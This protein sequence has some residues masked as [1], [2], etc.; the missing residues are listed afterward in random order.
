MTAFPVLLKSSL[1][2]YYRNRSAM[3][4]SLL[5]PLM[6][7]VIFGLLNLGANNISETVGVVD[8][9]HNDSSKQV[10]ESLQRV[11]L[12]KLRMG[13]EEPERAALQ[14]GERALVLVLPKAMG[15][16]PKTEQGAPAPVEITIYTNKAKPQD[17][18]IAQAI[19]IQ[20]LDQASFGALGAP[21]GVYHPK[22][23]DLPGQN[24][25]Y[26]DFLVPGIIALSIMQ[27]GI[28][29]VAFAFVEQKQNGVLRRL[30]ATP[31]KVTEFLGA[32]VTTRLIMA[33]AQVAVLLIV[34]LVAFHFH[35]TG[36][37]LE[38]M[39]AAIMGSAIFIAF[40]FA[41]AGF[42]KNEQ[43]VPAIANIAVLPMMFLSGIFFSRENMPGWLHAI[44]N[45]LPL[46]YV[47]DA[48]RSISLDGLHL[49]NIAGDLLG[50]TVWLVIMVALAVR[51]FRWEVT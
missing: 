19:V 18:A 38:L 7:M 3:F 49:W 31:M 15:E 5:V 8:N 45:L 35:L 1:K 51:F 47:T 36:N 28:F 27:T 46:T 40:G 12:L 24:Q 2:A 9:A 10:I 17:A 29:S 48:I 22:F 11:T 26:T 13:D 44:S 4:F 50:M 6:I 30:M 34:G 32:Q 43:V 41:I 20:Q 39:V 33:S 23:Q 25:T 42:A 14:K 16:A 21:G 37:I